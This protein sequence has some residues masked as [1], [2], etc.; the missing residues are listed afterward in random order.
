MTTDALR[1]RLESLGA[2]RRHVDAA[3]QPVMLAT[4]VD[5]PFSGRGWL[6]EIKYD[7]VRILAERA[8]KRVRLYGRS[9]QD[10]TA[11]YPEIVEALAALPVERAVLDGEVVAFDEHGRS[12]FQRLQGRMGLSHAGDVA[13]GR[14]QVPVSAVFFDCLEIDG[15]DLRDVPLAERKQLLELLIPRGTGVLGY[16]A[17]VEERGEEFF[18]AC[19][20]RHLEGIIAKKA[21][22]PYRSGRT[23]DWLKIKCQRRQEFVIGGYTDPQGARAYFG[24]LHLGVYDGDRLV[25]VSKVGTGFDATSLKRIR[26]RLKPLAREQSPFDVGTPTGRGHH[27]VEPKLVAEVRF[28]EWTDDGGL[29]HP[30][31]LGLR[32]DKRPR[33][34]KRETAMPTA[35]AAKA[36]TPKTKSPASGR[37]KLPAS[38][39]VKITRPEKL[40]WPEDGFT[41][42][43][44]VAYYEAIAPLMLPYLEDRPLVLVRYPD[45]IAGKSFFQKDTPDFVPDWVRTVRIRSTTPPR[46]IDYVVADDVETL[47][48][49]ANLGTIPIHLWASRAGSLERPDWAVLDLDPKG[50][51][52]T[53]VVRMAQTLRAILDEVGVPSYVKTSGK[54]GLHVLVALGARY[55]YDEARG[56]AEIIATMAVGR[57]PK[58]ATVARPLRERGGKVYVDFGQNGPGQTIVAPFSVRPLPGAP[59]ACPLTWDEVTPKLGPDR[60]TMKTVPRRFAEMKDPMAPVLGAGFDLERALRRISKQREEERL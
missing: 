45:G 48:Y 17:H 24:A 47:R 52:F 3:S 9:G 10:F 19:D 1:E 37:V 4:L 35:Q 58:I 54:T 11:R 38:G 49:L 25:Y 56:F 53:H 8:G 20:A 12:S 33:D 46:D 14:R 59:V 44:L 5:Q 29:R 30:A 18:H 6:F 40:F 42:G 34:C 15:H 57:E 2:P 28:T 55:S 26:D 51:P 32:D 27:W 16:S 23:R 22:G 39:R 36:T 60:F 43:D 21:D 50:A 31:F 7:G 13:A 41:K